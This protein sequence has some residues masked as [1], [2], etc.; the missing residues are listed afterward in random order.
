MLILDGKTTAAS[1]RAT[2]KKEINSL[3]PDAERAPNLAVL[4][5]GD[6][7]AS[8]VYV[9]NKERACAEVGIETITYRLPAHAK[10]M[11]VTHLISQLNVDDGV[12]GILLQLPLPAPIKAQPC[13]EAIN[14]HKDVDGLHPENQGN[15]SLGL[16]GLRPC[17]PAGVIALLRHYKLSVDGKKA[18]VVGRSNLVGRPLALM[19]GSRDNNATVTMCHSGTRNLAE[20]CR[21]A[22]FLFTAV[23]EPRFITADMVREGAVVVDIGIT[24]QENGLCGDVDFEAVSRKASALTPV[25]GG[26]GPMTISQLLANTVKAWKRRNGLL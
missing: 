6:D 25:P 21:Q 19:L 1:L 10:Q 12:D 26:I 7:P 15:L 8:Q 14:P 5:V 16:P 11:D 20:E 17:T 2:L 3:L 24:R 9:R 23:G 4:L 13:L 22:D 18:V